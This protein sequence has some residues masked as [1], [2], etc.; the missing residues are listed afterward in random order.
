[1]SSFKESGGIES[2][3]DVL[4]GLDFKTMLKN[5][6]RVDIEHE[7]QKSPRDVT[8]TIVKNK[9]GQIGCSVDYK[10]YPAY[11]MFEELV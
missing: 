2:L 4:I 3:A 5:R 6:N 1:M 9:Q 11:N 8:L 7:K 10:Y